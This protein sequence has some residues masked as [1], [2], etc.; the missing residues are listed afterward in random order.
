MAITTG[1][2]N[3]L[4][5]ELL[6]RSG[7]E[8]YL[9]DWANSG[10]TLDQIRTAIYNSPEGLQYAASN[11]SNLLPITNTNALGQETVGSNN[12]IRGTIEVLFE[13][14]FGRMPTASEA[15]S[16]MGQYDESGDI[17][18]VNAAIQQAAQTNFGA[19]EASA[20]IQAGAELEAMRPVVQG[21]YQDLFGRQAQQQGMDYWLS[22]LR[23]GE[24]TQEG[25]RDALIA[26]AQGS[27]AT[28]YAQQQAGQGQTPGGGTTTTPGGGTTTTSGGGTTTT[29][30]GGTTTTSGGGTTTTPG[31]DETPAWFQGYM[32]EYNAMQERLD[33]LTALIEQ[34]QSSGLNTDVETNLNTST[35][36]VNI[37]Q[38]AATYSPP[39]AAAVEEKSVYSAVDPRNQSFQNTEEAFNPYKNM[40]SGVYLT[41]EIMDAYRYQKFYDQGVVSPVDSGIGSLSYFG[42]PPSRI[43]A[44]LSGF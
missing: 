3:Q 43:Q 30:G 35:S 18:A 10:M 20:G 29:S 31:G 12:P 34:M 41:P 19:T 17:D 42:I 33:T 9:S 36:P 13:R 5:Q 25:L 6:G 23:S 39:V 11:E 2:V 27:D 7:Q 26:G 4:Y 37:S 32:D 44:S 16:F 40:V 38:P 14:Q 28:Y 24:V 8:Q 21:L 22:Q 1:Q 15:L